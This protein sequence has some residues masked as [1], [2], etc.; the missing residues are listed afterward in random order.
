MTLAMFYRLQTDGVQVGAAL[1]DVYSGPVD[2]ACWLIGGGPSL[3]E[4]PHGDIADSPIPKMV[5]NLAG[6]HLLRPTFWTSYDPSARF[7]RSVYLDPGIVKFVHRRRSMDLVPE[8][9]YKVCE[10]PNTYFFERDGQRGVHDFLAATHTG[11]IDW[12]DSMVQAIDILYRLGFR[13]IYLAGC[14]MR[15]RLSAEQLERAARAGVVLRAI[16]P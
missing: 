6:S 8:T 2:S 3:A 14:E 16:A 10:C 1:E 4:L 13:V 12:A 15:V 7:H 9:T 5:V 11:I